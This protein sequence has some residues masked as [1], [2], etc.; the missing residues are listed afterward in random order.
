MSTI[1]LYAEFD[2]LASVPEVME[3]K[4]KLPKNTE[5]VKIN[6][7]NHSQFGH[8]GK[9]LTDETAEIYLAEQHRLT[10]GKLTVFLREL[11]QKTKNSWRLVEVRCFFVVRLAEQLF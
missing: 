3:N 2:G 10:I 9:L 8:L 1:K 4:N 7:G 5:L 11:N 6:G